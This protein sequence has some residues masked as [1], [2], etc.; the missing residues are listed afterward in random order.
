MAGMRGAAA[1]ADALI[2]VYSPAGRSPVTW[3][4]SDDALPSD[5]GQMSL[6]PSASSPGLTYRFY[7]PQSLGLPAPVFTFGEG[8]SYTTF[9]AEGVV[10]PAFVGPCDAI[11]VAVTV[12]NTGAMDSDV[13]VQVC[14]VVPCGELRFACVPVCCLCV[15]CVLPVCLCACVLVLPVCCLCACVSVCLCAC[16]P[17]C[18]CA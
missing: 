14:A 6:Y 2:G 1:I 8:Y 7:D 5:R 18:L 4:A 12:N 11:P 3:Y 16:V 15:A 17:V 13:V 10:A 9:A